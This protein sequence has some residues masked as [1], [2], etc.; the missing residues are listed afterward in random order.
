VKANSDAADGGTQGSERRGKGAPKKDPR[1]ME[2]Q[3][4]SEFRIAQGR[5][6][7]F[8]QA[9]DV[10]RR[11]VIRWANTLRT[12]AAGATKPED[13]AAFE[14]C[15]KRLNIIETSIKLQRGWVY[16]TCTVE[17][18]MCEFE[19][20]WASLVQF[21]AATPKQALECPFM[22]ELHLQLKAWAIC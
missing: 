22:W 8:N 1:E 20:G 6:L 10:Q 4:W 13:R 17:R 21:C 18:A 2:T 16:R 14:M 11:L 3:L 15:A 19:A 5:S 7:F 12:Q 9:S